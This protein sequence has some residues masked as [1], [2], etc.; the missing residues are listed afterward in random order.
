MSVYWVSNTLPL[1]VTSL[2]PIALFP[3]MDVMG[4]N[5]VCAQYFKGS[6]VVFFCG[7]ALALGVE[8]SNLHRR[9]ALR[10]LLLVGTNPKW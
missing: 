4:T 10:S 2:L 8:Q 5:E 3:L 9:V 1:A 6:N 7:V